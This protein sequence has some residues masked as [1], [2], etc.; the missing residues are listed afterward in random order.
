MYVAMAE[1]VF[2]RG[3][4]QSNILRLAGPLI[5]GRTR[6]AEWASIAISAVCFAV[7]HV[8]VQGQLV[9]VLTFL[10]GLI[11]GWLFIRT[12]SLLAPILFHGLANV[13]Y[14]MMMSLFV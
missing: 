6:L 12:G 2:F 5:G 1:E 10:P 11:L 14:V 13:C 9:S 4:V 7:A 8:I 3:Y